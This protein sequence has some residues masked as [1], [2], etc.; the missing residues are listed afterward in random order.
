MSSVSVAHEMCYD[1][2]LCPT[3]DKS[4]MYRCSLSEHGHFVARITCPGCQISTC[5]MRVRVRCEDGL[6]RLT[7]S[8]VEVPAEVV[9]DPKLYQRQA[10]P[11]IASENDSNCGM[12]EM[13]QS[14]FSQ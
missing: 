10:R 4:Q 14:D 12:C 9:S 6:V 13:F 3:S 5:A 11:R 8:R 1:S 7:H 2:C